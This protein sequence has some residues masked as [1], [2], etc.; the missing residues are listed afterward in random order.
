MAKE[1]DL[2][3]KARIKL[4]D[5]DWI[6]WRPYKVKFA[7]SDIFG[8]F[9]FVCVKFGCIQFVQVTTLPNMAARRNKI[10]DF[11]EIAGRIKDCYVWGYEEK[12]KEFRE[13]LV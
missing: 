6:V 3:L 8:V 10:R 11:F 1:R 5:D 2:L 4:E 13:F 9:D 12:T 7:Q